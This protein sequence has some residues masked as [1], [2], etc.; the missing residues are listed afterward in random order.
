MSIASGYG[1]NWSTDESRGLDAQRRIAELEQQLAAA[2][3]EI[4]KWEEKNRHWELNSLSRIVE[5]LAAAQ[6]EARELR[7]EL[8]RVSAR[9]DRYGATLRVILK[10]GHDHI[11][12]SRLQMLAQWS[13][14]NAS[15]VVQMLEADR[16]ALSQRAGQHGPLAVADH[17]GE[18]SEPEPECVCGEHPA[19][20]DGSDAQAAEIEALRAERDALLDALRQIA[21]WPDGGNL[22]GQEK[23][24]RFAQ[25]TID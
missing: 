18:C 2:Q 3:A 12:T 7:A 6:A 10:R 22:Y 25:H 23:I 13:Y 1:P 4:A 8:A 21:E 20:V 24:K 15:E 9:A 14:R 11:S 16:D 19:A 17:C 5:Q